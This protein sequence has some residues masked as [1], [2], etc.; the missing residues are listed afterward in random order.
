MKH[1][2]MLG[3]ILMVVGLLTMGAISAFAQTTT[4]L[5][6]LGVNVIPNKHGAQVIFVE[7]GSP[8]ATADVRYFDVITSID[9]QPVKATTLGSILHGYHVGDQITL[10]IERGEEDVTLDATLTARPEYFPP[11]MREQSIS[12]DTDNMSWR[13][14]S[15]SE[16]EPLY[17]SG[18][19]A[20]DS[21]LMF[22]DMAR[23]PRDLRLFLEGKAAD[24]HIVV[25]IEREDEQIALEVPV[26]AL[27]TLDVFSVNFFEVPFEV[28]FVSDRGE[29]GVVTRPVNEEASYEDAMDV[30]GGALVLHVVPDSAA[31]KAGLQ[32]NDV[33][34]AVNDEP[35]NLET[36]LQNRLAAYE[37][38]DTLHLTVH[39]GSEILTLDA[40]LTTV[41]LSA[42]PFPFA[43]EL[44][45]SEAQ[46]DAG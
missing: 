10:K 21:I 36:T 6:Y 22:G 27:R 24:D 9:D 12:Y 20:G 41:P 11:M 37:A 26:S 42:L 18:L 2:R 7:P 38:G 13:I 23:S 16:N 17:E 45:G 5:P 15:L 33:I 14:N 39:R 43:P 44:G 35:V 29:L 31:A 28:L 19:R 3:L 34:T 25:T 40:T 30:I 8:A 46:S 32:V 1:Y 4:D